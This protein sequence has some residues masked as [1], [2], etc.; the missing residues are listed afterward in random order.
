MGSFGR[1]YVTFTFFKVIGLL[2]AH[3][4]DAD[5]DQGTDFTDAARH[6][7]MA[8]RASLIVLSHIRMRIELNHFQVRIFLLHGPDRTEGDAVLIPRDNGY[9]PGLQNF[10]SDSLHHF[11][12]IIS[13]GP[14]AST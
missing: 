5:L 10:R 1:K 14:R 11:N 2:Y 4:A 13:R 9:L 6:G 12:L 8:E 7:R 3:T